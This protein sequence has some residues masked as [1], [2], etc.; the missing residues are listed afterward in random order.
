MGAY[1]IPPFVGSFPAQVIDSE[2]ATKALLHPRLCSFNTKIL[3]NRNNFLDYQPK[4][5]KVL[6]NIFQHT[7]SIP[8]T[9][10]NNFTETLGEKP[11][12]PV[13][14]PERPRRAHSL[15]CTQPFREPAAGGGG[16][17]TGGVGD[18][19]CRVGGKVGYL[20]LSDV[21]SVFS[22]KNW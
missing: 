3:Q 17:G 11:W 1:R 22:W 16:G 15:H 6:F 19:L 7:L 4:R 8:F 5:I 10:F 20:D 12:T 2:S 9:Y 14:P 18:D 21:A 13:A